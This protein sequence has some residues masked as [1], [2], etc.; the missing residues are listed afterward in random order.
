VYSYV[1]PEKPSIF[2]AVG[3]E[4][5]VVRMD[6]THTGVRELVSAAL[7][8]A[9]ERQAARVYSKYCYEPELHAGANPNCR[10]I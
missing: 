9:M 2:E 7:R 8:A 10:L 4:G 6:A 5:S 1:E 3:S